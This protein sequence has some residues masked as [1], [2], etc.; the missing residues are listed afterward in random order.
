[1]CKKKQNTK[2]K[3]GKKVL[4]KNLF[5]DNEWKLDYYVRKKK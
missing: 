1:M 2:K 3:A 4:R 5:S